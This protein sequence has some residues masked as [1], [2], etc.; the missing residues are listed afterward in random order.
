MAAIYCSIVSNHGKRPA[1]L[2][3]VPGANMSTCVY[4]SRTVD[5][6]T[7][8]FHCALDR[9]SQVSETSC[10]KELES[11]CYTPWSS[12]CPYVQI[13]HSSSLT[14]LSPSFT[15]NYEELFPP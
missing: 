2:R 15:R 1:N 8:N 13:K 9:R 12:G 5:L 3:P 6:D 14:P 10:R 4:S 11:M 7:I